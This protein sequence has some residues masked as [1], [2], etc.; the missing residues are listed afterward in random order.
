M[1]DVDWTNIAIAAFGCLCY[2]GF[3]IWISKHQKSDHKAIQEKINAFRA[4]P[5]REELRLA[6]ERFAAAVSANARLPF[7]NLH[8][9]ADA[10]RE[11]MKEERK[12]FAA[13]TGDIRDEAESNHTPDE[14]LK[15]RIIQNPSWEPAGRL[16]D[17]KEL[18]T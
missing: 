11:M 12:R 18:D 2:V 8:A 4:Q 13:Y 7:P 15:Y 14:I 9:I 10:S 6:R 5:E 3:S 1:Q 17:K 16:A